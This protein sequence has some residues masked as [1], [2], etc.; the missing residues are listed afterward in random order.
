MHKKSNT[1][2]KLNYGPDK[3]SQAIKL[4]TAVL[5][6]GLGNRINRL[7]ILPDRSKE[8]ECTDDTPCDIE[9][10]TI[11]LEINPETCFIIIDKGPEA[12]LPEVSKLK[13]VN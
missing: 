2:N 1:H 12:N 9:K 7:C 13:Y 8:W 10:V 5:M 4:L 6:K 11:A 3:R